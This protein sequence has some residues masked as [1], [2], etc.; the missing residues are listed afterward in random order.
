MLGRMPDIHPRLVAAT[1]TQLDA[2]RALIADGAERVGW[3]IALGIEEVEA[4]VGGDPAL[5]H[6]TTAT[7]LEPGATFAG[8]AA[9][10]QLRAETEVMVEVGPRATVAGLAV[11][12]EIV[13][14]GRPPNGLEAIVAA[15]VYHRAVAFGPTRPGASLR[16]ALARLLVG[17]EV[18]ELSEVTADPVATV[19][20]I[21]G[22]LD[23]AGE[24]LAPGDRILAGSACHVQVAPGDTVVAEIDGLGAVEATIAS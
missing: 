12:L 3:K 21:G 5:G 18:R 13:D 2:W 14:T 9:V 19:A 7:V 23:A 24:G 17:G 8:A 15:N 16:G 1:R 11:A 10:R 20:A 22:L 6:I 4:V